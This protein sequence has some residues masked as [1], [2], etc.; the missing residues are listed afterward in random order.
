MNAKQLAKKTSDA[1]SS[2]RYG[3]QWI[4]CAALLLELKFTPEQAE[5][6]LR[7]KNMRW[8]ADMASTNTQSGYFVSFAAMLARNLDGMKKESQEWLGK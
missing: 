6:Q 1:F 2:S 8:A 7:S 5:Q 4:N 3:S